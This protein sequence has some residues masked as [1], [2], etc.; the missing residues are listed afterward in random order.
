MHQDAGEKPP[1]GSRSRRRSRRIA[2][3]CPRLGRLKVNDLMA[4]DTDKKV[5]FEP[6]PVNSMLAELAAA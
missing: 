4:G 6:Q 1:S 3:I 5:V 2:F